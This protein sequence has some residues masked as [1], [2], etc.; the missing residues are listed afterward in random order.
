M[1]PA[2]SHKETLQDLGLYLTLRA[3]RPV[4]PDER[5]ACTSG[6]ARWL[7]GNVEGV[8]RIHATPLHRISFR[9]FG[10]LLVVNL[11]EKK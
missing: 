10:E 5:S 3:M 1:S 4:K 8:Q 2:N 9:H 7:H 11:R 6:K